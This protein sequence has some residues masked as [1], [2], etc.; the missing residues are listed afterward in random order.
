M[1]DILRRQISDHLRTVEAALPQVP[2]LAEMAERLIRCFD[3]GGKLLLFGNGGSAADAQHIAAE[4]I[5]RFK[6]DRRALPAIA[7]TT[8]TSILTAVGN[9]TGYENVFTRQVEALAAEGDI[10]WALSVS[11]RSPNVI[12]GLQAARAIGAFCM[13]FTGRGGASMRELCHLCFSVDH[14]ASDRVQEVHQLAYHLICE[15]VEQRSRTQALDEG[16]G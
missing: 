3:A 2:L 4:L 12:R 14:E 9:D 11:G 15:R 10:A 13:G 8:D 16:A 1:P 7:L 5:G 6:H